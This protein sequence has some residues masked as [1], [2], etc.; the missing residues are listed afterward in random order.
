M[1]KEHLEYR[2]GYGNW[3]PYTQDL[4]DNKFFIPIEVR[5]ISEYIKI[6]DERAE[7]LQRAIDQSDRLDKKIEEHRLKRL[8]NKP[9]LWIFGNEPGASDE[10]FDEIWTKIIDEYMKY[11]CTTARALNFTDWIKEN[12]YPPLKK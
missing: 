5:D 6:I 7:L 3:Y 1:V 11:D 12:Y 10:Y 9:P 4:I 8:L 2:D